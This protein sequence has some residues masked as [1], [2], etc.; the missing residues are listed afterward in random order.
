MKIKPPL[1]YAKEILARAQSEL[2][3]NI[4]QARK[5]GQFTID[6][7]CENSV[8]KDSSEFEYFTEV[9]EQFKKL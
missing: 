1:K 5:I 3:I 2:C 4:D 7:L 9:Q 6:I 8:D